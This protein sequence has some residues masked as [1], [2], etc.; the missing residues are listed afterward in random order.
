MRAAWILC[1]LVAACGGVTAP[2]A[3]PAVAPAPAVDA[4]EPDAAID[5][6]PDAA[7]AAADAAPDAE[8]AVGAMPVPEPGSDPWQSA[9]LDEVDTTV[10]IDDVRGVRGPWPRRTRLA[11][12]KEIWVAL[13]AEPDD[14]L[15]LAVMW[16]DGL[17]R[18][19]SLGPVT[20]ETFDHTF[21]GN[22]Y[23]SRQ[24]SG[25]TGPVVFA[26]RVLPPPGAATTERRQVVVYS[27]GASL[28]V[29]DRPLSARAW[30]PR[31]RIDFRPG[32]TFAG[33]GTT[34]PH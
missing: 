11:L 15:H 26:V 33:I 9:T 22:T 25:G 5:A 7:V 4:G 30:R 10:S 18:D 31:L 16:G 24:G 2:A 20:P 6:A 14:L 34:D 27:V 28:R 13:H 8:A 21:D 23:L 17:A 3:R 1:L 29:V 19:F 32:A 12:G